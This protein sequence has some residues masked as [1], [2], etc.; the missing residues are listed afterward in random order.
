MN[1]NTNATT[2]SS[3][4]LPSRPRP[5]QENQS[6]S[7]G[8]RNHEEPFCDTSTAV[9]ASNSE[10]TCNEPGTLDTYNFLL[11]K[12]RQ[13]ELSDCNAVSDTSSDDARNTEA[14]TQYESDLSKTPCSDNDSN[15]LDDR[16]IRQDKTEVTQESSSHS[17]TR[18]YKSTYLSPNKGLKSNKTETLEKPK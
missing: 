1:T 18:L 12:K 6:H 10:R 11:E 4:P 3:R 7:S 13:N 16:N 5:K 15:D 2:S 17:K 9:F 8:K 14:S